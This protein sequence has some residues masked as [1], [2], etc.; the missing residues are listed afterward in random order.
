MFK[1]HNYISYQL[2]SITYVKSKDYISIS[3]IIINLMGFYY[4]IF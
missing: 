3:I 2:I 1:S 4:G